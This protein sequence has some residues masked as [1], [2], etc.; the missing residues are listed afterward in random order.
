MF[1]KHLTSGKN[2]FSNFNTILACYGPYGCLKS[3]VM[4]FS[5]LL[6][7]R[8]LFQKVNSLMTRQWH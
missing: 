7:L 3:E 8:P 1:T 5:K 6:V 4:T 2:L